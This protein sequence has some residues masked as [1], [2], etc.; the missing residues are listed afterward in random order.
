MADTLSNIRSEVRDDLGSPPT[1]AISDSQIDTRINHSYREIATRFRHPEI[2]KKETI[3]TTGGTTEY[4]PAS[5]YWYTHILRDEDNDRVLRYQ[6]LEWIVAQDTDTNGQPEVYTL[7]GDNLH[8]Y[9]T[10]DGSYSLTNYY[11]SEITELSA[12]SDSTVTNDAWDEIIKWGAVWRCHQ[13]THEQD[14]MVHAR[15]IWRTLINNMPETE[16]LASERS[17]QIAGPL[18]DEP[19]PNRRVGP[20]QN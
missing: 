5:D 13:M 7:W 2:E 18:D 15:N 14:R 1:E 11:V 4:S 20:L 16:V 9:P 10:P 8:L 17:T 6:T 12:N 19:V 3:S